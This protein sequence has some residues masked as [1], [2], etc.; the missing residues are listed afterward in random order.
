MTDFGRLTDVCNVCAYADE[1]GSWCEL[2]PEL[3]HCR[4]CHN[5]WAMRTEFQHCSGCHHTF[6]NVAAADVHRTA[7][8]RCRDPATV[9]DRQDR[10]R[11]ARSTRT[12]RTGSTITLWARADHRPTDA[13][14]ARRV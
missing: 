4:R 2:I 5:T 13:P 8:G 12:M 9:L 14:R 6:S 11:L 3:T 7:D 10:N 1:H